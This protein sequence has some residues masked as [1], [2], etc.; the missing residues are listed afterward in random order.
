MPAVQSTYPATQ[1]IGIQGMIVNMEISNRIS[2]IASGNIGF[3]LPVVRVGAKNCILASLETL[4]AAAPVAQAG[5]TGN[6]TF[7]ATPTISAGA[8]EGTY[9][10]EIT[11]AATNA[12]TFVVEDPEGNLVGVGTV[13][14]AFSQ[15]GV[16]F[17]LQDGATDFAVND[18]FT[19]AVAPSGA[20]ADL[21][22]LGIAIRNPTLVHDTPDRYEQYD[23]VDIL[24]YGVI[25]V[26]AGATV[27][28][29]DPVYWI[30][31]ATGKYTNVAGAGNLLIPWAQFDSA[32]VDTG[33]VKV[34]LRQNKQRAAA[35]A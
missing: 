23:G 27:A 3:G 4:E 26:T 12:G 2:R 29:G 30:V 14:V 19:F 17:T 5:N 24:D 16:A 9:R 21:D 15:G 32:A 34:R 31:G 13:G 1:P 20:T 6:G 35:A 11:A 7:A 25:W 33:L 22:I 8:K 18:G 10:V 28:A